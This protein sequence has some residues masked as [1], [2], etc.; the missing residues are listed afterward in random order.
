MTQNRSP[1]LA[2]VQTIFTVPRNLWLAT[3][4]GVGGEYRKTESRCSLLPFAVGHTEGAWEK[5]KWGSSDRKTSFPCALEVYHLKDGPPHLSL[6]TIRVGTSHM[7]FP[8]PR[9]SFL[10]SYPLPIFPCLFSSTTSKSFLYN[11]FPAQRPGESPQFYYAHD[12]I[13]ILLELGFSCTGCP[14]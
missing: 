7:L 11:V 9:T 1:I 6:C 8:V 4:G 14:S 13:L 10:P 2:W 5:V 3:S 12:A